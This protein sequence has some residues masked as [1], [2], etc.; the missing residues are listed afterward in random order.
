M[1]R[2]DQA[3]LARK[4]FFERLER[5]VDPEGNLPPEV[6]APLVKAAARENAARLNAAKARKRANRGQ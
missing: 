4:A 5:Q 6:R 2:E 3:Y 1:A